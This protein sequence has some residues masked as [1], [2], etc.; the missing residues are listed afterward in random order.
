MVWGCFEFTI[1]YRDPYAVGC[2]IALCYLILLVVAVGWNRL[3]TQE[4]T[5]PLGGSF[6]EKEAVSNDAMVG[7][8]MRLEEY[9]LHEM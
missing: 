6:G 8:N 3:Q 9:L 7:R 1:R 5:F 2:F 4:C